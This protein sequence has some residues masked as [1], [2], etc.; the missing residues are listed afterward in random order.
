M[1]R[2][3]KQR[4]DAPELAAPHIT[5][6]AGGGGRQYDGFVPTR[7]APVG[8]PYIQPKNTLAGSLAT[9]LGNVN[10]K[11]GQYAQ[12]RLDDAR[13]ELVTKAVSL[14]SDPLNQG[15]AW[16]DLVSDHPFLD[17]TEKVR[18]AYLTRV[19][20]AHFVEANAGL[21][22]AYLNS[23]L[24]KNPDTTRSDGG[25]LM[26]EFI[27]NALGD[28]HDAKNTPTDQAAY[29]AAWGRYAN[30][31]KL[32]YTQDHEKYV[33]ARR[34]TVL[35]ET[36]SENLGG[37][38]DSHT[39]ADAWSPDL[40]GKEMNQRLGEFLEQ[41][42]GR[43]TRR[44][45]NDMLVT[46]LVNRMSL[47]ETPDE[48]D[49]LEELFNNIE[50]T[51]GNNLG[52]IPRYAV[53]MQQASLGNLRRHAELERHEW[54]Q[55][56]RKRR[57]EQRKMHDDVIASLDTLDLP[58]PKDIDSDDAF[59]VLKARHPAYAMKLRRQYLA[60]VQARRDD[61]EAPADEQFISALVTDI[62]DP[63][64]RVTPEDVDEDWLS[65]V[66]GAGPQGRERYLQVRE[67]AQNRPSWLKAYRKD[68]DIQASLKT[69]RDDISYAA[70]DAM[71]A[72]RDKI[73]AELAAM[74]GGD[75]DINPNS[76]DVTNDPRIRNGQ[77]EAGRILSETVRA[78]AAKFKQEIANRFANGTLDEWDDSEK[79][80]FL[81]GEVKKRVDQA[82]ARLGRDPITVPEEDPEAKTKRLNEVQ[83]TFLVPSTAKTI[84]EAEQ[85][86]TVPEAEVPEA[87]TSGLTIRQMLNVASIIPAKDVAG[88]RADTPEKA[89]ALLNSFQD[90]QNKDI[91]RNTQLM[92]LSLQLQE[93]ELLSG[94]TPTERRQALVE[95]LKDDEAFLVWK[96]K[97]LTSEENR[98]HVFAEGILESG[99][100]RLKITEKET[101]KLAGK[102]AE[103]LETS[104]SQRLKGHP[105]LSGALRSQQQRL[106][107][108][109]LATLRHIEKYMHR[110]VVTESVW[111]DEVLKRYYTETMLPYRYGYKRDPHGLVKAGKATTPAAILASPPK[112]FDGSKQ[113]VV[114]SQKAWFDLLREHQQ[115]EDT[116]VLARVM[117]ALGIPETDQDN[118][119]ATQHK[120][121]MEFEKQ[122]K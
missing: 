16:K 53:A 41:A 89:E 63:D 20:E 121:W 25:V 120:Q 47:A 56:D 122:P 92:E 112:T 74:R 75:Q 28:F 80:K 31:L 91:T 3:K 49:K 105:V 34:V 68:E 82:I 67:M 15:R 66:F 102:Y 113:F 118:F 97:Y 111:T 27:D 60:E 107:G 94:K 77:V 52:K 61:R 13:D 7:S 54:A 103:F 30:E 51:K 48:A 100:I 39:G 6:P 44:E 5:R 14:A 32:R 22:A 17:E 87:V 4:V 90:V 43:V 46:Q 83:E 57:D 35:K 11:L 70:R 65:G 101:G 21:R 36:M 108:G 119:I 10:K 78:A 98:M 72:H 64:V 23:D 88:Y 8:R 9:A 26:Q 99:G 69:L 33:E 19:A 79:D 81:T 104:L 86:L 59:K 93:F 96:E 76:V 12:E 109:K 71:A 95:M 18:H 1:A 85:V 42:Q 106:F 29:A 24:Y 58:S 62:M 115:N 2:Q 84:Q 38:I 37:T 40:V 117:E 45:M 50:T 73:A 110:R 55:E 114:P 116:S